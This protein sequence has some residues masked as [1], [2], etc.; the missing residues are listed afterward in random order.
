MRSYRS[1]QP[2]ETGLLVL[3]LGLSPSP[4]IAAKPSRAPSQADL[5]AA[6]H[7]YEMGLDAAKRHEWEKSRLAFLSAWGLAR[8]YRLAIG[9][10][11]TEFKTKRYRDAAEHLAYYLREATEVAESEPD[12]IHRRARRL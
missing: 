6:A 10:G 9:L 2:I 5:E 1:Y 11:Q 12:L 8:H 7:Y 4:A 3:I